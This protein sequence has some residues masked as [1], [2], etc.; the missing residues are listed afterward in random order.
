MGSGRGRRDEKSYSLAHTALN[1]V[2]TVDSHPFVNS[3]HVRLL[4]RA[5]APF[6]WCLLCG[7]RTGMRAGELLALQWGDVNWRGSHV[8]VRR[9]LVREQL[10]TPKNHQQRRIDLSRQLRLELWLWRRR[11]RAGVAESRSP[12]A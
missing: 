11:Q 2:G 3:S 1:V 8:Q 4:A 6:V 10:T 7:L 5:A 12:V 9:N